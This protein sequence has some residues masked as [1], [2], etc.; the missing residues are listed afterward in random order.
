MTLVFGLT[1]QKRNLNSD[2]V[3]AACLH[4]I[5]AVLGEG[6]GGN[7][8]STPRIEVV[9]TDSLADDVDL[10]VFVTGSTMLSASPYDFGIE[11]DRIEAQELIKSHLTEVLDDFLRGISIVVE[12]KPAGKWLTPQPASRQA[13]LDLDRALHLA[14]VDT[15]YIDLVNRTNVEPLHLVLDEKVINDVVDK[16]MA[17]GPDE[18]KSALSNDALS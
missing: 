1:R 6:I 16:I 3:H 8:L 10:M 9:A 18:L 2:L 14:K 17:D 12:A 5:P 4:I 7:D 13:P 15:V 11:A